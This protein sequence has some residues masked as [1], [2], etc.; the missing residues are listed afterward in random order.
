MDHAETVAKRVLEVILPGLMEF[1]P[2]QSH[3][4]SDFVLRYHSGTIAAVEVTSS[5][6]QIQAE[7]IAGNACASRSP[8]SPICGSIKT[9][10]S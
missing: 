4:E 8:I 5:V 3:G 10:S 2:L 7:T 9:R 6:D 1:Q